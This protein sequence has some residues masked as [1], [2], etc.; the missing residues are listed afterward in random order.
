M[1]RFDMLT[2]V[3]AP[4]T[5]DNVDTDQIFP[6]RF[7]SKDRADGKF[8]TYFLHDQR[9][10]AS[11]NRNES[12]ILN[13]ERLRDARIIVA[14]QNYACGSARPG[15]IYSHLDY[16]IEAIIAESFGPVF[17]TVAYKSGLLTIRLA[18]ADTEYMRN[19]LLE[20]LGSQITVDL[21]R[22]RVVSPD[23]KEFPF[24]IDHFV[25]R[26]FME[27]LSEIDLTLGYRAKIEAL[28]ARLRSELPWVYDRH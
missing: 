23:G 27:G 16:G 11:G 13:D 22:Q 9:F 5:T 26:M 25:K 8:G 19:R 3:A 6:S 12:F 2:A 24:E 18:G 4:I 10:D 17:P 14:S 7:S 20:S 1:A 15:A 28:E 21:K